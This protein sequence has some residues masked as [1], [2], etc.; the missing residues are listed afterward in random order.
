MKPPT[1]NNKEHTNCYGKTNTMHFIKQNI[2]NE[3]S[4]IYDDALKKS[5]GRNKR[6]YTM[7]NSENS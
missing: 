5:V 3:A 6:I 1:A 4:Q 7:Y 2:F